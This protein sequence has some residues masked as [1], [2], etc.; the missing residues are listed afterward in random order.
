MLTAAGCRTRRARL[1][2]ALDPR[3]DFVL[4]S[5][6]QCLVYLANYCPSPFVF[7]S[8][9]SAAVLIL[10]SDGS[11]LL[12]GD[13]MLKMFAPGCHV[14]EVALPTWYDGQHTAPPRGDLLVQNVLERLA[15]FP[16]S[17]IGYE[18]SA[19]P[20]GILEALR[21]ARPD[22][23]TVPVDSVL[24]RLKRQKDLD[25]LAVIRRSMA[26]GDAA[27]AAALQDVRPGMSELQVYELVAAAACEAAGQQAWVYGDF[28]SGPRCDRERGGP[29]SDRI[30]EQGDLVLLDFSVVIHG[31]RGD[32]ANTFACGGPPTDEQ[33]R[34]YEAC[35]QALSA[36]EQMIRPGMACRDLDHAVRASF[37]QQGLAESFLS[38]SGHGLGLG[39][40]D[41]PYLVPSSSDTLL[42]GDIIAIEPG[43]Y[44]AGVAGMRYE[45]NY[46]VTDSGYETLSH[47]SLCIDQ[48]G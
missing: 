6:P 3:P 19:V 14:D 39:H 13:S 46:L 18:A 7:R 1:W 26:A 2:D 11:S 29:P 47:L 5:S 22:L 8:V 45:R 25:E 10:G 34:L 37:A 38:H 40:P 15:S 21:A 43:Q 42:A 41:P 35:L 24:H 33:R 44:I 23:K 9:N 36:G 28:V 30:I 12:V 32:F 31:Y 16:G 20:A 17:R 27:H 48:P 4:I